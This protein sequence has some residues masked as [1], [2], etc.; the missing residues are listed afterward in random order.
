MLGLVAVVVVDDVV[1]PDNPAIDLAVVE[2]DLFFFNKDPLI[3]HA[4]TRFRCDSDLR[5]ELNIA[6]VVVVLAQHGYTMIM[7]MSDVVF[8][9]FGFRRLIVEFVEIGFFIKDTKLQ[10][11][12]II[13]P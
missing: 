8:A 10:K 9:F 7:M 2:I 11:K 3:L 1:V 5:S 12:S 13:T 4:G 6:F